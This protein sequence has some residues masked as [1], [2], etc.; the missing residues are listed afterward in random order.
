MQKVTVSLSLFLSP[1][2]LG[3]FISFIAGL[4]DFAAWRAWAALKTFGMV[5]IFIFSPWN[6]SLC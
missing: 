1:F 3:V 4:V 5:G 2:S 6:V